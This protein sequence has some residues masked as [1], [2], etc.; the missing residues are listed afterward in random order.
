MTHPQGPGSLPGSIERLCGL[1]QVSRAAYYRHWGE[2]APLARETALRIAIQRLA[3]SHRYYGYRRITASPISVTEVQLTSYKL[4][5]S[6]PF[7]PGL[8][9]YGAC[10]WR[11]AFLRRSSR[12]AQP[13]KWDR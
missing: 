6:G 5:T 4:I 13:A 11:Q 10:L 1:G 7:S 12:P 3:I 2:H 8:A 9:S